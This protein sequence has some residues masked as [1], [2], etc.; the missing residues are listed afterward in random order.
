VRV[1]GIS[2]LIVLA[3]AAY[4]Q[5][6]HGWAHELWTLAASALLAGTSLRLNGRGQTEWA[7][8]MLTAAGLVCASGMIYFSGSGYRD[9]SLLL[10]P[11]ILATGA[12]LHSGRSYS[13]F[14]AAVVSLAGVLVLLQ[15]H[16]LLPAAK[17]PGN[18]FDLLMIVLVLTLIAL[19][20]GLL[21]NAFRRSLSEYRTLIEQ[22]G[23]GVVVLDDRRRI[24]MC[25]SSAAALF[26]ISEPE[27]IGRPLG[28]L[29]PD[30]D[31]PRS[32]RDYRISFETS[33]RHADGSMRNL[34]VTCTPRVGPEGR[35]SG[36][37]AVLRD[38][39]RMRQADEQIRLLAHALRS[40]DN[41]VAISD[42]DDRIIYVNQAFLQTYGYT[43]DELLGQ[44][45]AM[46]R[47]SRNSAQFQEEILPTTLREGWSGELWNRAKD[48]REFPIALTSSV[49]RNERGE[50]IATVGVARDLTKTKAVEGA[51][52]DIRRRFHALLEHGKLAT[53]LLDQD[54]KI[55]FCNDVL[56]AVLGLPRDQVV[57][58][59]AAAFIAPE[60][61]EQH[62]RNLERA[63]RTGEF[64]ALA[65]NA[66]LDGEGRRRWFQWSIAPLDRSDRRVTEWAGIG[67]EITEQRLLREQYLQAQKLE[68]VGRLAGGVAHDFNNLLTVINGYS[69]MLLGVLDRLDPNRRLAEEIHSAGEHAAALTR[70]LLTFSRKQMVAPRR[71]DVGAVVR[72]SKR[73][74]E[75]LIGEDIHLVT[76]VEARNPVVLAD[77][78]QMHQV[79]MNLV[80]NAR[81]AMPGGGTLEISI[82]ITEIDEDGA[83]GH[84]DRVPGR[85][86]MLTVADSGIGMD[87]PT[88]Q[89]AFEPFF[90]TKKVGKG[91]GLGLATVYGIVKQFKGWIEMTSRPGAGTSVHIYLPQI[92]R[93]VRAAE[94]PAEA[95]VP[96]G[97]GTVLIV[98]DQDLVRKYAA[99]VL[100]CRGYR[101]MAAGSGAEALQLIDGGTKDIDLL[102]TDVIMPGMSG[103]ELADRVRI[104]LPAIKV[105]YISGY[106][107]DVLGR[108]G[109]LDKGISLILKPFTPDDLIAKVTEV[110]SG[111]HKSAATANDPPP[112]AV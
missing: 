31:L 89:H 39:T 5:W 40:T 99:T 25:N 32:G 109:V 2:F 22:A 69:A 97:V 11:A 57:G 110:M 95:A 3:P 15:I 107:D 47:S 56:A 41:C 37:I 82:R 48:G 87:E 16:G 67:L 24:A 88:L 71:T 49:V 75:R 23:E 62:R 68:T 12:L 46:V 84:A 17:R 96:V 63:R 38:M 72:D 42:G 104:V 33:A 80:V 70:Q 53:V 90:T 111:T 98:E 94:A 36:H 79:I 28:A 7:A 64:V 51:L 55:T 1:L 58:Q 35:W 18:Y 6:M 20:M 29:I 112:S 43:E 77:P 102:L 103:R 86:V 52:Q 19:T 54:G 8:R 61:R 66:I 10:F 26:G 91:T 81:D 105:L 21:A 101:T 108:Y 92:D 13:L 78:D 100:E 83:R 50:A 85:F 76:T 9:L 74:L 4:L 14:T 59:P 106:T 65:E 45:I 30:Q 27:L 34:L 60:F 93:P 44:N 73:M